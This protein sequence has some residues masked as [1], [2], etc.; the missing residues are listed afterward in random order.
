MK[1][2]IKKRK[3]YAEKQRAKRE[4][5]GGSPGAAAHRTVEERKR[6]RERE[7]ERERREDKR[8][9]DGANERLKCKKTSCKTHDRAKRRTMIDGEKKLE[10]LKRRS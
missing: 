7:R 8:G 4:E 5:K 6:E 1:R 9:P 3:E 10:K 2:K